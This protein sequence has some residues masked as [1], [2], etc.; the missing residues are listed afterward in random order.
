MLLVVNQGS[1]RGR[2]QRVWQEIKRCL[3]RRDEPYQVLFT[4]PGI[5]SADQLKQRL[6]EG[7]IDCVVAVGGDGTVSEVAEALAGTKVPLGLIPAG[8]G[9]DIAQALNVPVKPE[10]ALSRVFSNQPQSIDMA[11]L[12]ERTMLGFA[13]M[14]FDA[15][16]A[17]AVNRG[18]SK[19]WLG[20]LAYGVMAVRRLPTFQPSRVTL[21]VDG[22]RWQY[23]A[24]WM[25][26]IC[27]LPQFGGGMKI[28]PDASPHD[29]LLDVCV[30]KEISIGE[31]LR[32]FPSVY[33]GRHV[34]HPAVAFHQGRQIEVE[35][36]ELFL[37]HVDGDLIGRGP[38]RIELMPQALLIL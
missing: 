10:E 33:R 13:G 7:G 27:N 17:D 11:R 30:V 2:G 25:V 9:N 4:E 24:V 38:K 29:G 16:V 19:H 36:E 3:D 20:S 26:D 6:A 37:T 32:I 18:K 23:D 14:G 34:N 22:R 31:F 1:G 8:T 28:C 15:D 35:A 5:S 12:P 21:R